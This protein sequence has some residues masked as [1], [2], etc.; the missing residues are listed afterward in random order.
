MDLFEREFA[1][2]LR[3]KRPLSLSII[4][5][6]HFKK[7]NDTHGHLIGDKILLELVEILQKG[8]RTHDILGRYGGEEFTILLP[9][10]DLKKGVKVLERL[11][12]KVE[13]SVFAKKLKIKITF[14]AGVTG[15]PDVPSS[16]T[17]EMLRYADLALYN[18]KSRGRNQVRSYLDVKENFLKN[19][20]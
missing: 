13:A 15:I 10:T 8:L 12:K 11:R 7:V 3:Y 1:R 6:D 17:D 16:S 20:R 19:N 9:E 4:D 18:A 2:A 5:I 14:S